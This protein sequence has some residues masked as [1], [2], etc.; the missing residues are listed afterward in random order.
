MY[1]CHTFG[2]LRVPNARST[3]FPQLDWSEKCLNR[4]GLKR[5]D[6]V[7]RAREQ[8]SLFDPVSDPLWKRPEHFCCC[9]LDYARMLADLVVTIDRLSVQV[10]SFVRSGSMGDPTVTERQMFIRLLCSLT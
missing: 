2:L 7:W 4:V 6:H 5:P 8:A 10:C 1:G 3:E 9:R